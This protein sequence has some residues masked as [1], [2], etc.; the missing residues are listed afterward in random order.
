MI[1]ASAFLS[2]SLLAIA[3]AMPASAAD[4]L[5]SGAVKSAS[6]E[7]MG[8]VAVAAKQDGTTITTTVVTTSTVAA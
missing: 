7:K 4:V 8:G 2:A 5:F 1:K 3:V 6:G